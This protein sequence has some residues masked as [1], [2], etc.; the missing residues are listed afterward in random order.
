MNYPNLN[1]FT[2]K[3]RPRNK[4]GIDTIFEHP[5]PVN[6]FIQKLYESENLEQIKK[7]MSEYPGTI[8]ITKEEDQC[9]NSRGLG[10]VRPEGWSQAYEICGI[11]IVNQEE[12]KTYKSRI[13]NNSQQLISTKS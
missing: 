9:L 6:N 13:I 12:F 1:P 8:I 4:Y 2:S 11:K 10:R 7:M 3:F 5:I